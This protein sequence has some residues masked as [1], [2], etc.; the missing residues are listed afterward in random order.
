MDLITNYHN[1]ILGYK[2][3]HCT[4]FNFWPQGHGNENGVLLVVVMFQR[5]NIPGEGSVGGE[6]THAPTVV[7]SY[8]YGIM[9]HHAASCFLP[10][11]LRLSLPRA[12]YVCLLGFPLTLR[13]ECAY[14]GLPVVRLL[15][16][17]RYAYHTCS[18]ESKKT[19][20]NEVKPSR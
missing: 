3:K 13:N 19:W 16:A 14:G 5:T 1:F 20:M 11:V 17:Y 10:F 6:I 9:R 8:R 4:A 18:N 2:A 7:Y 15:R 12:S